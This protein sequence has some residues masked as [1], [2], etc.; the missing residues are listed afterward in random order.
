MAWS[1]HFHFDPVASRQSPGMLT[2]QRRWLRKQKTAHPT[3]PSVRPATHPAPPCS[4]LLALLAPRALGGCKS[5]GLEM[6]SALASRLVGAALRQGTRC[7]E[8]QPEDLRSADA[9]AHHASPLTHHVSPH[10]VA[11]PRRSFLTKSPPMAAA[12]LQTSM[13]IG[14][15][16]VHAGRSRQLLEGQASYL[17]CLHHRLISRLL[18]LLG[19]WTSGLF[20]PRHH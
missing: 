3:P 5:Q 6:P 10:Q 19:T 7:D 4:L 9:V 1:N 20:S 13:S 8:L 16:D 14:A 11:S 15:A 2:A 17:A 18:W 12:Q